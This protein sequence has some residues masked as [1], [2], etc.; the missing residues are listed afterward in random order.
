MKNEKNLHGFSYCKKIANF[1]AFWWDKNFSKNI[2]FLRSIRPIH[3]KKEAYLI[4]SFSS[5][6]PAPTPFSLYSEAADSDRP[7]VD[8]FPEADGKAKY[9]C[10]P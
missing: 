3:L 9:K 7:P 10:P 8:L 2:L 5:V 6:S 1:E 4:K